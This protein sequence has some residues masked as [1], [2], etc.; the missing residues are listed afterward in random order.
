MEM[1]WFRSLPTPAKLIAGGIALLLLL[2][3]VYAIATQVRGIASDERDENNQIFN[4]GTTSERADNQGKVLNDVQDAR[5]AVDNPTPADEQRVCDRFDR[6]CSP[7][8]NQ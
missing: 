4:Q 2:G 5:D 7:T 1:N 6:N 3:L 8:G